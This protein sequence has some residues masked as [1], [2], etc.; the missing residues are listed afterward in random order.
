M[1]CADTVCACAGKVARCLLVPINLTKQGVPNGRSLGIGSR[2]ND[3]YFLFLFGQRSIQIPWVAP[4]LV[5]L[6][7]A[8]V[9]CLARL[10]VALG[11][12]CL[13][14]V[15]CSSLLETAPPFVHIHGSGSLKS[16]HPP[17]RMN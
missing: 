3:P 15:G 8:S 16:S 13:A 2:L 11:M 4:I 6:V 7:N 12:M 1:I 5:L 9:C 17:D 10:A 14:E